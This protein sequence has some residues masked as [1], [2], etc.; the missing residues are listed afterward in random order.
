MSQRYYVEAVSGERAVLSGPEAHH[1]T[2][3]MRAKVGSEITLFDG[4][5]GEYLA[6]VHTLRRNEVELEVGERQEVDR[7][8][9]RP[10]IAGVAMPKGDRQKWLV[11]KLTELGV[12]ELVPLVTA[13]G[14]VD[15]R[16]KSLGKLDRVVI[17]ASKQCERNRLMTIASP[18]PLEEFLRAT[19]GE[20]YFA[21]P[22]GEPLAVPASGER[23]DAIYYA[24]GP[25]GGFTDQ[26]VE[27]ADAAGWQRRSLGR[28]ILRIETAAVAMA[29]VLG[30]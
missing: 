30:R 19:S 26:E 3:V 28:S 14:V 29:A 1:L 6:R 22:E 15:L 23:G 4:E 13:R 12:T 20:R 17:E 11:E 24:I 9:P 8:L 25:E 21:H 27:L 2:H 5:G 18:Q 16:D 10:L 7:E